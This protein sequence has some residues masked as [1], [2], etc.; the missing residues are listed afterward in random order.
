MYCLQWLIPVLLIPKPLP[1]GL[2]HNHVVFLLVYLAGFFLEQKPCTVC[3]L[4]FFATVVVLCYSGFGNCLFWTCQDGWTGSLLSCA[5]E[6]RCCVLRRRRPVM[7]GVMSVC[8]AYPATLCQPVYTSLGFICMFI[9]NW[10][11]FRNLKFILFLSV[12]ILRS[13]RLVLIFSI[14]CL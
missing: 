7:T 8:R 10:Q 2:I 4:V 5:A 11:I 14:G 1:L 13:L 3:S 12:F 9:K 6:W